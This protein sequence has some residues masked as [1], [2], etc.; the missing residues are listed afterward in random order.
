MRVMGRTSWWVAYRPLG[1]G[2]RQGGELQGKGK[3]MLGVAQP[4]SKAGNGITML[5]GRLAAKC[6]GNWAAESDGNN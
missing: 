4:G 6:D 2:I 1:V 5:V 3:N